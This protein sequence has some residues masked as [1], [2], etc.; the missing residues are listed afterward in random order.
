MYGNVQK[1]LSYNYDDDRLWAWCEDEDE[2]ERARRV[3]EARSLK[4]YMATAR[5]RMAA[6]GF[7]FPLTHWGIVRNPKTGRR[8]YRRIEIYKRSEW[9]RREVVPLLYYFKRHLLPS[10]GAVFASHNNKLYLDEKDP[11]VK[12]MK[13][14]SQVFAKPVSQVE[15]PLGSYAEWR[16]THYTPEL[17]SGDIQN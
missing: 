8:E 2:T 11:L 17:A 16:R 6:R 5:Q 9:T 15:Q 7:T 1:S 12:F 4:R 13:P 14:V 3:I 10:R